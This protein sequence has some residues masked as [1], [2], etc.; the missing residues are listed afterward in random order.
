ME[1]VSQPRYET[2]IVVDHAE[3]ALETDLVGWC[4]EIINRRDPGLKGEDA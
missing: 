3:E 4:R 1:L 2:V